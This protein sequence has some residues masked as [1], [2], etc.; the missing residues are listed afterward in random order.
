[1]H[2]AAKFAISS[3]FSLKALA[4]TLVHHAKDELHH[5]IKHNPRTSHTM[6]NGHI[7]PRSTAPTTPPSPS[8]SQFDAAPYTLDRVEKIRQTHMGIVDFRLGFWPSLPSTT[9]F[10]PRMD[11]IRSTLRSATVRDTIG[12]SAF[13]AR[14]PRVRMTE[15]MRSAEVEV[16]DVWDAG[17]TGKVP[18][19]GFARRGKSWTVCARMRMDSLSGV[20]RGVSQSFGVGRQALRAKGR[21]QRSR[22]SRRPGYYK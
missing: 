11:S 16:D 10:R 22:R 18:R 20:H 5:L 21:V 13:S 8:T 6:S 15:V 1:M 12:R 17:R 7:H 2:T 19:A 3:I 14:R 4:D 9:S